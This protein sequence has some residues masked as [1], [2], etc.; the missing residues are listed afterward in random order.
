MNRLL[1]Y[2]LAIVCLALV[3]GC[4]STFD[5][6][7]EEI[8]AIPLDPQERQVDLDTDEQTAVIPVPETIAARQYEN[9]WERIREG[10]SVA[11][12]EQNPAV[13]RLAR[14]FASQGLVERISSRSAGLLY[15]VVDAVAR[16]QLPMEL[17]L[18]PF[19][20]SGYSL[21]ASSQA[22]AHGAWQFI[23]ATAKNYAIEID[24]FRDDRRN[25][26]TSTRAALDY[27]TDL[28]AMFGNW[29]LALAAYNCGEKRIQ[30]EV[31]RMR[32]RGIMNPGFVDIAPYLPQET[33]DYVPRILALRKII[34]SPEHYRVVLPPL[35]NA[36]HYSVVEIHRD[37][38]VSLV[39]QLSGL[40]NHS[41][42][43]LNPSLAAPI[44]IGRH[45]VQILLPHQNALRLARN[46]ENHAGPWISWR[47]IRITRT[48]SPEDIARRNKLALSVVL[49]ANPLPEGHHY[50]VGS[51][52]ILPGQ[53]REA[54][55]HEGVG[56]AVLLTRA[57]T[58]CAVLAACIPEEGIS[59]KQ[60]PATENGLPRR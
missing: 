27:L 21:D 54:I 41:L 44:I 6:P 29:P 59:G 49:M 19:V 26:I 16:R 15:Y 23:E 50:E 31:D 35:D 34:T 47:L 9:L 43:R 13:D 7:Y 8:E 12:L 22:H 30:N 18:V 11:E 4:A 3:A 39:A 52:L 33:R 42:L 56:R 45:G 14:R 40:S 46:M 5:A 20:E 36:P 58:E 51:T 55:S 28:H 37:I 53:K 60:L 2:F 24:R 1:N 10:L 38:D 32:R 48:T 57:A 25:M 17:V